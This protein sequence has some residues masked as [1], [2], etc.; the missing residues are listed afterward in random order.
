MQNLLMVQK[1]VKLASGI[2]GAKLTVRSVPGSA[3]VGGSVTSAEIAGDAVGS[4]NWPIIR[5]IQG[6]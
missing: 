2:D 3:L 5:S 1:H 4:L 6:R